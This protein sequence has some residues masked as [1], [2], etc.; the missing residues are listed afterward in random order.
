MGICLQ[1]TDGIRGPIQ[2]YLPQSEHPVKWYLQTGEITPEFFQ[3]Y[4]YS[5]CCLLRNFELTEIRNSIVVG[6]DSRD[7]SGT[8]NN[9]AILGI[10][11]AG[12]APRSVGILPTPAVALHM[13]AT[14]ASAA[15]V[16]TAS[17]N[18]ADQNGIKIFLGSSGLKLFPSDE[19]A[20]T[21]FLLKQP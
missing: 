4:T 21:E 14:Q 5:I 2:Q 20:L 18:P 10:L 11:Q 16:L 7:T 8:F 12:L 1:G 17:H 19:E 15:I 6:W 13:L 3:L 9:A